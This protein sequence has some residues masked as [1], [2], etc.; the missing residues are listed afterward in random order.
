MNEL[1]KLEKPVTRTAPAG[2]VSLFMEELCMND[3]LRK[4][5]F[6][7]YEHHLRTYML[8]IYLMNNYEKLY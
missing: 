5:P 2:A 3:G 7:D 1:R 4:K 6:L 8:Y